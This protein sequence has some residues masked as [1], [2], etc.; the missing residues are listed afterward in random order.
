MTPLL[1]KLMRRSMRGLQ[2]RDLTQATKILRTA[3]GGLPSA[4]AGTVPTKRRAASGTRRPSATAAAGEAATMQAGRHAGP[5]GIR[6]WRLYVPEGVPERPT[7]GAP[8]RPLVVMLHG[9]QQDAADFAAGTRMNQQAGRLGWFVLYP[10]Q[11]PRSN[12]HRCWNWFQPNDQQRDHGEP[13]VIA[14]MVQEVIAHHPV[15]PQRVYVAGLSAGGSMAAI[16]GREYPDLFAAV[17]VHSGLPAGAAQDVASAFE[18]M[19]SGAARAPRSS[20]AADT[21]SA[22]R[23][24]VAAWGADPYGAIAAGADAALGA[25]VIVF[26]GDADTVVVPANG[27]HVVDAHLGDRDGWA[28]ERDTS[29]ASLAGHAWTRHVYRD[30]HAPASAPSRAEHWEI[31]GGTHG[32]SGGSRDGSYTDPAGPDATREMLRFFAAHPMARAPAEAAADV[33]A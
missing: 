25:P 32:W 31:H 22:A 16:L 2:P 27:R 33:M 7:P 6:H 15:D 11:A 28:V 26:H 29:T 10:E 24:T 21:I 14:G 23:A 8:L 30:A 13:A 20:A 19:R 3:L 17:G 4:L 5:G 9:C 18:A 1:R 12:A